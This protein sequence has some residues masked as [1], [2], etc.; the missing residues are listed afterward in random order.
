[1]AIDDL[2]DEHEQ[3]ERVR[4]W[5]R[6]NGA[7]LAGGVLI[8]LALI[9]GWQWWQKRTHLQDQQAYDRYD[10]ASK[11]VAA[12]DLAKAEVS[13]MGA[14]SGVYGTLAQLS[15]AKAQ[16]DGKKLDEA[17]ATLRAIKPEPALRLVVNQRLARLLIE[18]GKP[19]EAVKVIGESSL[20]SDLE[21][22]GDALLAAGKQEEAKAAYLKALTSMD[23]AAPERRLVEIKLTHAGGTPPEVA[24]ST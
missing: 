3:G 13:A 17:I 5:L 1:M 22:R 12:G 6:N 8:G 15:L 14:D 2:L 4:G 24:E 18:T 11:A 23:V 16:V 20:A 21:I 7:G 9:F 10:Q 19:D